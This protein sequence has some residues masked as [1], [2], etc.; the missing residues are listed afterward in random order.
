M[1]YGPKGTEQAS[2][3][4]CSICGRQAELF[5]LPGRR[6]NYCLE[7]SA[8]MATLILL[9]TEIDAAAQSG[10]ETDG[11]ITEFGELSRRILDRAQST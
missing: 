6:E 5:T 3:L 4:E 11:L 10:Q 1:T 9:T 7:C 2:I 8:D